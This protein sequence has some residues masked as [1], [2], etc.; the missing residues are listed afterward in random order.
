MAGTSNAED[1]MTVSSAQL[2]VQNLMQDLAFARPGLFPG[3]LTPPPS[4]LLPLAGHAPLPL[5]GH[6][7]LGPHGQLALVPVMV[8]NP[9]GTFTGAYQVQPY[10]SGLSTD[11]RNAEMPGVSLLCTPPFPYQSSATLVCCA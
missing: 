3:M 11:G 6:T 4:G 9:D 5:A 8:Q 7:G 10:P 2:K 1:A